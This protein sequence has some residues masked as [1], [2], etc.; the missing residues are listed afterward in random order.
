MYHP[1]GRDLAKHFGCKFIETS[2]KNRINVDEAFSQLVREIRKYNKVRSPRVTVVT[3][4]LT[5]FSCRSNKRAAPVCSS[6]VHPVLPA[7]MAMKRDTQTT[8]REGA[9][10]AL[11]RK[12]LVSP[13]FSLHRSPSRIGSF[14][15]YPTFPA[16]PPCPNIAT[17]A[18]AV[19]VLATIGSPGYQHL[20]AICCSVLC[21]R[22]SF[23]IPLVAPGFA[24]V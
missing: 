12:G 6:P 18:V 9:V 2:A 11:S 16:L 7:C 8:A 24:I 14:L 19:V 1:E 5:Q 3:G 17:A 4:S 20:I 10:A 13:P 22:Y 15:R 21:I 23:F